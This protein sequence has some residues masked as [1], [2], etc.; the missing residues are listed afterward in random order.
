MAVSKAHQKAVNKYIKNN[1]DR[2]NVTVPKGQRELIQSHAE[3]QGE[4]V[5]AFIRRAI[6]ETIECDMKGGVHHE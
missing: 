5:N 2:I 4:S 1:Y 6:N 3:N